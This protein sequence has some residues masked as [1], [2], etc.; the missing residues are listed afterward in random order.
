[1]EAEHAFKTLVAFRRQLANE[2]KQLTRT[3]K[4]V[5]QAYKFY[6]QGPIYVGLHQMRLERCEASTGANDLRDQTAADIN[7]LP[8]QFAEL[9]SRLSKVIEAV[10]D[11]ITIVIGYV[12]VEDARK[13]RELTELTVKLTESTMRQAKWTVVLAFLELSTC[14]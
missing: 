14:P 12:Q 3:R 13:S 5:V 7:K 6:G 9:D 2:Y 8:E 4:Q 10:N 1:M 11:E